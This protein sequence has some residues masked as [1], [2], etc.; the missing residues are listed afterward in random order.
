MKYLWP[1]LWNTEIPEQKA[2]ALP[3]RANNTLNSLSTALSAL[4]CREMSL[5]HSFYNRETIPTWPVGIKSLLNPRA[6]TLSRSA[7]KLHDA[8]HQYYH[9]LNVTY[10]NIY[11]ISSAVIK[12]VVKLQEHVH[13]EITAL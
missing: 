12:L 6:V 5:M 13:C 10:C 7:E 1:K 9:T 8:I 2:I 11:F 4:R 3:A